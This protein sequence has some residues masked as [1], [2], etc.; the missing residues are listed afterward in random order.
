MG[1]RMLLEGFYKGSSI[2]ALW[3]L[4]GLCGVL[5]GSM[6]AKG[7][8]GGSRVGLMNGGF[9]PFAAYPKP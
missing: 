2:K 6:L 1:S 5:Q 7:F 8:C 9:R 4:R 3:V